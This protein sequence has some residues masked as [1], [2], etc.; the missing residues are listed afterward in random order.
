M[1][2]TLL[3]FDTILGSNNWVIDGSK[4]ESGSPMLAN[5]PHLLLSNPSRWYMV[6][7]FSPGINVAGFTLPGS[8]FVVIGFNQHIAWG[9][10]NVMA[11]DADFY[12]EKIDPADSTRYWVADHWEKMQVISETIPIQGKTPKTFQIHL[13]HHLQKKSKYLISVACQSIVLMKKLS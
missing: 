7:L 3:K 2:P 1:S 5:D 13:T 4:S 10:T 6:H 8:P 12:I 9:F 11:D